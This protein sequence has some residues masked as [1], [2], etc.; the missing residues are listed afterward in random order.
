M[1]DWNQKDRRNNRLHEDDIKLIVAGV[2]SSLNNHYCRFSEIKTRDMEV[3]VEF[4]QG[5]ITTTETTKKLIWK[6]VVSVTVVA[7]LGWMVVGFIY[8]MKE[9]VVGVV[10]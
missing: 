6:I 4:V 2:S 1:T 8:R 3:V 9:A 10:K 5:I 7:L